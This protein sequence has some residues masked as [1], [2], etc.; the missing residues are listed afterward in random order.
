MTLTSGVMTLDPMFL[1]A[2]AAAKLG[3]N[4][5]TLREWR[6]AGHIKSVRTPGG[7]HRYRQS[8]IDRLLAEGSQ[9]RQRSAAAK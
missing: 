5:R 6:A 3:V 8:E 2:A 1:P 7:H 9:P 4:V